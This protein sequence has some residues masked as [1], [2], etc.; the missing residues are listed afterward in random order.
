[1]LFLYELI[2]FV[3]F[4]YQKAIQEW[5]LVSEIEKIN[6]GEAQAK[7]LHGKDEIE[8]T[9]IETFLRPDHFRGVLSVLIAC[10]WRSERR[11]VTAESRVT[12]AANT[13]ALLTMSIINVTSST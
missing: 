5:D 12:S 10:W 7:Y 1:M 4:S 11:Q 2:D 9:F 13:R 8:K 3:P 6:S